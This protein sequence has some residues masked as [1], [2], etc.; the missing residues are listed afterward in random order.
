MSTRSRG[1]PHPRPLDN[2]IPDPYNAPTHMYSMYLRST[3]TGCLLPAF[4]IVL[5]LYN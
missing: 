1:R 2:L 5:V 4:L 3:G